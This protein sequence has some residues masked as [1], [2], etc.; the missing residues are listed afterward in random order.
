MKS[1]SQVPVGLLLL[2]L[3]LAVFAADA[4]TGPV[5]EQYGPVYDYPS[6]VF[7]LDPGVRYRSVMDVSESPEST[8]DLNR[9]IESAARYL[10][11]HVRAG[12]PLENLELA[13]VLHG[14][15]GKD[16]LS[17]GA[18]ASRHGS[19]NPNSQLLEALHEA[20][21][22]IY[23][24]GQTAGFR[25]FGGYELNPVVSVATSAMSVLTRLQVEGW[26]LL[27]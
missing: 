14:S 18:Y 24:C 1:F 25:G 8:T 4:S 26:A 6:A 2:H 22:R 17:D 13:L 27:P 7:K 9:H 20:G 21:V 11:M 12:V 19:S 10:N 15:A 3:S 16:A 23:L 5:I